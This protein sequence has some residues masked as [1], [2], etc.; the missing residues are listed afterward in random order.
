MT[1]VEMGY[2]MM[3]HAYATNIGKEKVVEGRNAKKSV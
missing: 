1:A 3:E 2:V